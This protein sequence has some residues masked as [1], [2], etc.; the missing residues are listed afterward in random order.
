MLTLCALIAAA[1]VCLVLPIF[2]VRY[3]RQSQKLDVIRDRMGALEYLLTNTTK[4]G[5]R[6]PE[7]R[8]VM[9]TQYLKVL[10]AWAAA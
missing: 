7:M 3:Y 9:G 10:R 6:N 1:L 5:K 2:G 8:L 4:G